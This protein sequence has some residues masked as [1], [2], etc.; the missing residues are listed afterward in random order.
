MNAKRRVSGPS[1]PTQPESKRARPK[2]TARLD[3]D[4]ADR[5]RAIAKRDGLTIEELLREAID[6]REARRMK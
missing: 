6:A 4:F 1:G 2:F 3:S 5:I